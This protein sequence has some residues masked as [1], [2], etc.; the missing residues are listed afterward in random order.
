MLKETTITIINDNDITTTTSTHT[1]R[2]SQNYEA[3]ASEFWEFLEVLFPGHFTRVLHMKLSVKKG[4]VLKNPHIFGRFIQALCRIKWEDGKINWRAP[5]GRLEGPLE[6]K[7]EST[8][9]HNR[10]QSEKLADTLLTLCTREY[11]F[12]QCHYSSFLYDLLTITSTQK[13]IFQYLLTVRK[14]VLRNFQ[15]KLKGHFVW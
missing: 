13:K 14:Q 6:K 9:L 5:S 4:P 10:E 12:W 2:Y 8:L 15:K 3:F 11:L 7:C 1:S